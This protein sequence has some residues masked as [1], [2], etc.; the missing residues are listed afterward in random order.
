MLVLARQAQQTIIIGDDIVVK[1]VSIRGGKVKLGI[2]APESMPVHRQEVYDR[3]EREKRTT[4][5]TEKTEP[6]AAWAT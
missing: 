2:Q 5:E 6:S 4:R 1:V 3:I